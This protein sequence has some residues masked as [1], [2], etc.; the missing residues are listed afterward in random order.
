V[1]HD[2]ETE[3]RTMRAR[4]EQL[5]ATILEAQS[6]V[7]RAETRNRQ[8]TLVAELRATRSAAEKRLSDVVTALETLRLD[9]L[10]LRAGKGSAESI[11]QNLEAAKA[12]G[13]DVDRLIAGADEAEAAARR[14]AHS[15]T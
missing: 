9:L 12:L 1:V 13:E 4:V 15:H 8:E 11:T 2:L 6:G 5:D 10:R 14:S 7:A 3:A